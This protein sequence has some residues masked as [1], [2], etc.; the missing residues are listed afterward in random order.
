M[1]AGGRMHVVA[2]VAEG[3]PALLVPQPDNEYDPHAVAVYTAP[4]GALVG[5]VVSSVKDPDHVGEI[6]D[7]DRRLLMDRQAGYVPK[8]LARQLAV[9]SS[10]IVGYVSAVRWHPPEYDRYGEPLPPHPAGFDVTAWLVRKDD[11]DIAAQVDE[12]VQG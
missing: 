8:E 4:R 1:Q 12:E 2:Y 9:P 5:P 11:E 7:E 10:G 6:S 3:D